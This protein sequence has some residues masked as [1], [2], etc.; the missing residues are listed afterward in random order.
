MLPQQL[1]EF[2][3]QNI[4]E[5]ASNVTV[6]LRPENEVSILEIS[7]P[8]EIKGRII[9]KAGRIIKAIRTI[10]SISFPEQRI[11]VKVTD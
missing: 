9:G 6:S 8:E 10:I 11:I 7:A 1:L 3:L 4:L 2:L 5:D